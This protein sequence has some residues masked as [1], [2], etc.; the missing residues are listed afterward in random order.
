[1]IRVRINLVQH[2]QCITMK[3]MTP[4]Q[5][6]LKRAKTWPPNTAGARGAED[7]MQQQTP[8]PENNTQGLGE[9]MHSSNEA[10]QL[11]P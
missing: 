5:E 1:M 6:T 9:Q 7:D 3:L 4:G 10:T 11:C 2:S 8:T